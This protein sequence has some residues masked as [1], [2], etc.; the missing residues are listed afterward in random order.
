MYHSDVTNLGTIRGKHARLNYDP[1]VNGGTLT[2]QGVD[3]AE[4]ISNSNV[5]AVLLH[6]P[7]GADAVDENQRILLVSNVHDQTPGF[8]GEAFSFE[9]VQATQLPQ[10]FIAANSISSGLLDLTQPRDKTQSHNLYVII[11]TLSGTGAAQNYFDTVIKPTFSAIGIQEFAY[12]VHTTSSEK[13]ILELASAVLLPRANEGIPQTVVLLSGDGGIVD[14]VNTF[15]SAGRSE[16]Y[17]KPAIGLIAMGT[18]NAFANSVGL[19]RDATRGLRHFFRGQRYSIPT[20]TATFSPGSEFLV[21]EGRKLQPLASSDDGKRSEIYGSV[22][23]SWAL[24][25][26]LV[27][28]S[29]TTELRKYGS[30]RF[31]MAAKELLMPSDGSAPHAY[32]GRVTFIKK[33]EHG[34]KTQ[35]VLDRKEHIY[36]LATLVSNLEEKFLISPDSRPLDR[37]MRLLHI[38]PIA[39]ADVMRILGLAFQGGKHVEDKVVGYDVVEGI[40]IDFEE[41]EAK[42]RRVC[43]DGKIVRVGEGGWVD[44]RMN[45]RA[46]DQCDVLDIIV[47]V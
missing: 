2:I 8:P 1:E 10:S 12:Y 42:W 16:Q 21:D 32:K 18:G 46:K 26:S 17:V 24:H 47:D 43:V 9:S 23:C 36:I 7:H 33:S 3:W 38:K 28:D 40:R 19:N 30:Q 29:D 34:E 37:Q 44:V 45:E 6:H 13:S 14:I 31:Q 35:E 27:A 15:M 41:E 20:F 4:S 11:S 5:I 22:V 39:S 25:A